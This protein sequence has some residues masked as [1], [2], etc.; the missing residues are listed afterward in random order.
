LDSEQDR[1]PSDKFDA[2]KVV[3][4]QRL[5]LSHM[6]FGWRVRSRPGEHPQRVTDV[7]V[8]PSREVIASS[9]GVPYREPGQ[10]SIAE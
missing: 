6:E 5:S 8:R 7:E 1:I 9:G 2:I 3:V 10:V 4:Q